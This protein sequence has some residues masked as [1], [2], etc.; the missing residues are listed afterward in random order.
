VRVALGRDYAD[1]A[2]LR[3]SYAGSPTDSLRVSVAMRE[4][5]QG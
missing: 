3:G 2:P 1:V 5:P 4:I